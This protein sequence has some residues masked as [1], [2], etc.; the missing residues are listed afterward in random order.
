MSL[1]VATTLLAAFTEA[2]RDWIMEVNLT[3]T[4]SG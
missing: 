3:G 4:C 2:D 1:A